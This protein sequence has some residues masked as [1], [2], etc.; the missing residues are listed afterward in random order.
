MKP[1]KESAVLR[2]RL[3][4]DV[5]AGGCDEEGETE[6][7]DWGKRIKEGKRERAWHSGQSET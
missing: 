4:T 6:G 3:A 7:V 1:G 5:D 2:R